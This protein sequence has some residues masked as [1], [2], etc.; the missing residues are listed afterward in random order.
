MFARCFTLVLFLN[1]KIKKQIMKQGVRH[2][3][4]VVFALTLLLQG[5]AAQT[6]EVPNEL[7]RGFKE[8][9]GDVVAAFLNNNVELIIPKTDNFFTRQQAKSILTDFFRRNPVKDFVVVHKGTKEN[10]TF[11]M[12]TYVSTTG[13]YRVSLF[14]RKSGAQTLVYQL[15]IENPNE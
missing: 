12:A 4:G 2:I 9:K 3:I 11:L 15:R 5:L 8:G 14:A 7:I 13:S 6:N 1:V 10:A